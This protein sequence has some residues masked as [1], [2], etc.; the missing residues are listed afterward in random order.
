MDQSEF[1]QFVADLWERQGW[2]AQVKQDDGRTFV[3]VQRHETAEEGLLW[4]VPGNNAIGGQ[5]VQQFRSLCDEYGV[6]E[7]GIVAAGT[8]S[9]HARKVAEGTGLELRD[10]EAV[11]DLLER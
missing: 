5:E 11:T 10:G 7:A 1:G 2:Q 9:D 8:L 3:A 6:E 4:A